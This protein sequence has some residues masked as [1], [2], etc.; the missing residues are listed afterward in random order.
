MR[1]RVAGGAPA[2]HRLA[3]AGLDVVD[4]RVGRAAVVGL[5]Q[6]RDH[7]LAQAIAETDPAKQQ[8]LWNQVQQIQYDRGGN[9][10]WAQPDNLDATAKNVGGFTPGGPF[11]FGGFAFQDFYFNA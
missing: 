4:H 1:V 6:A 11:E 8:D 3:H 2:A 9:I 5:E 10:I 7:L